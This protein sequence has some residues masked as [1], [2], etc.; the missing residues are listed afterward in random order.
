MAWAVERSGSLQ[1]CCLCGHVFCFGYCLKRE[2]AGIVPKAKHA[3]EHTLE[4][5]PKKFKVHVAK[6]KP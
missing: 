4:L 2:L 6:V 1:V 3:G 5:P